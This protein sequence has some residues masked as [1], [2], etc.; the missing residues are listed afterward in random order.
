MRE[1]VPSPVFVHSNAHVLASRALLARTRR[2]IATSRRWLNPGFGLSGGS[3][4]PS[5]ET[6]RARLASGE[7]FPIRDKARMGRGR[8]KRCAVCGDHVE[9]PDIEYEIPGGVNGTVVCHSPCY[10][11]WRRESAAAESA[12]ADETEAD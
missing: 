1:P 10:V 4:P 3:T 8:G 9:A 12:P 2:L 7:L 6:V 5:P 11:L